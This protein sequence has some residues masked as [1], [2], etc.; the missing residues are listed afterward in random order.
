[1]CD[2]GNAALHWSLKCLYLVVRSL[3]PSDKVRL[4]VVLDVAVAFGDR[5][6]E[7]VP[8]T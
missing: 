1:M 4:S 6:D 2:V 3:A 5:T 7:M 8:V